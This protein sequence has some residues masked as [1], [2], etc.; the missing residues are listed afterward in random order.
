MITYR[1]SLG[2]VSMTMKTTWFAL[3]AGLAGLLIASGAQADTVSYTYDALGRLK[4]VTYTG[5]VTRTI[6]YTYDASGN[7]TAVT[8]VS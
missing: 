7:R 8:T 1:C 6:T 2:R 3:L 5:S 4:T